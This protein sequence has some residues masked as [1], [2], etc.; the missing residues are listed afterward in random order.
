MM[1]KPRD[2]SQFVYEM[3]V[4]LEVGKMPV[5]VSVAIS[6]FFI[7]KIYVFQAGWSRK[8]RETYR[9]YHYIY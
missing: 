2:N 8:F 3:A 9:K 7:S 1:T 6:N 5:A 4:F